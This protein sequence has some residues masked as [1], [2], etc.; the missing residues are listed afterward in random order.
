MADERRIVSDRAAARGSAQGKIKAR[1]SAAP[2]APPEK[3][4]RPWL[5]VVIV[6]LAFIAVGVA[7]MAWRSSSANPEATGSPTPQAGELV[8]VDAVSVNLADDR[9]LRIGLT[10]QM[11]DKAT[12]TVVAK[13]QDVIID[14]MTGKTIEEVS[15]PDQ[16]PAIKKMLMQKLNE[17][18]GGQVMDIY[19]TDFVAQ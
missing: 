10:M 15:D 9:Y 4:K 18:Y 1:S 16:R 11:T 14:S 17:A 2:A 8:T 7:F 5:I 19:F 12:D 6:L 3:K 13:A